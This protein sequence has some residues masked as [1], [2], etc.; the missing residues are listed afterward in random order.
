LATPPAIFAVVDAEQPP[1]RMFLG[2]NPQAIAKETY[3]GR[4]A[5][6][7]AWKH[8]SGSCLWSL[9]V[10]VDSDDPATWT[11]WTRTPARSGVDG[12]AATTRCPVLFTAAPCCR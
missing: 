7:D 12:T 9:M 5:E 11:S 1:L 8:I 4:I 2:R 6:R 3:A 10:A